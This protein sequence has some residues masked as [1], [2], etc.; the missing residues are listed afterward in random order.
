[1]KPKDLFLALVASLLFIA[2]ASAQQLLN[3]SPYRIDSSSPNV[4][5][6]DGAVVFNGSAHG[7]FYSCRGTS[8]EDDQVYFRRLAADGTPRGPQMLVLANTGGDYVMAADWDGSAYIVAAANQESERVLLLRVARD[9]TLLATRELAG[10]FAYSPPGASI[11][12]SNSA[13]IKAVGGT[14]F[15]CF[16]DGTEIGKRRVILARGPALLDGEESF[17]A[18]ALPQGS[19][20]NA[21]L[22]GMTCDTEGFLALIGE[23][24]LHDQEIKDVLLIRIDFDGNPVGAPFALEATVTPSRYLAGPVFFGDGYLLVCCRHSGSGYANTSL[25]FDSDGKTLAGPNDLGLAGEMLWRNPT[26]NGSHLTCFATNNSMLFAS[27]NAK[28]RIIGEPIDY[29]DGIAT[30]GFSPNQ[31]FTGMGNTLVYTANSGTG[32][33]Q[34]FANQ[35]SIPDGIAKPRV[36][37]FA[38]GGSDTGDGER[39][40]FWSATGCQTV[41]IRGNGIK[42][43]RLPPVGC[44]VVRV[45]EKKLRLTITARGPGGKAAKK[46]VIRP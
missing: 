45:S 33:F 28:G 25:V 21:N 44:A 36:A 20:G 1:M 17:A 8:D 37:Y 12:A 26:W 29:A 43:R 30:P 5:V 16:T 34:L 9:G 15:L 24:G 38:A 13:F 6:R 40:I 41:T 42:L 39:V 11:D 10:D 3:G 7:V 18:V 4:N 46:I 19:L 32:Y 2:S 27:F 35:V 31:A 14:V 22:L 23:R